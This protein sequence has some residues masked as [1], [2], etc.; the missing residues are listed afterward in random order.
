MQTKT[1]YFPQ[2]MANA[3]RWSVWYKDGKKKRPGMGSKPNDLSTWTT[4]QQARTWF[5]S[6]PGRFN[7]PAFLTGDGWC[8]LDLDHIGDFIREYLQECENII[9]DC[10]RIIGPTYCELSQSGEGLHFVFRVEDPQME[11]GDTEKQPQ[12]HSDE[13]HELYHADRMIALTGN[14]L[15]P[16]DS[17]SVINQEDWRRLY[18]LVFGKP[19]TSTKDK[20]AKT[21]TAHFNGKQP[22]NSTVK[23]IIDNILGG[24]EGNQFQTYLDGSVFKNAI[25]HSNED[26][27]CV[28]I[29]IKA[30]KDPQLIDTVFRQTQLYRKKWDDRRRNQTYGQMTITNA[31]IDWERRHGYRRRA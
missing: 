7:G 6:Q 4:Y 25:D 1:L 22:A 30:T 2:E 23:A 10:F 29:I 24:P 9:S 15:K 26:W 3:D 16:C 17:I 21:W 28:N 20:Q 27:A 14:Q 5:H 11:F 18:S 31:L 19:F 8:L 13:S 12:D